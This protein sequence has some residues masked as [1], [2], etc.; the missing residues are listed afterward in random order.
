LQLKNLSKALERWHITPAVA[1]RSGKLTFS[2]TWPAAFS[3]FKLKQLIGQMQVTVRDGRVSHLDRETEEKLALGKV[4]SILSLQTIPRRLKLDFSD[5]AYQGYSFDMFKGSFQIHKGVMSTKDS[6]IDGPVAYGRINGDLDL[7]HQLYD[8]DLRITP[9][10]TASL[11]IVATIAGGP[12]A[13]LATWAVSSLVSKGMQKVSGYSYK[14]SGPWM[15]P[16]VQQVSIDH[17]KSS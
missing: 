5:L 13:G 6:Y 3:Q 9:Y 1:A 4:L 11:P 2:G 7:V 12:V 14:I 17:S 10:I 8:L 16:V 15:N